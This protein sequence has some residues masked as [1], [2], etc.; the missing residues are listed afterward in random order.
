MTTKS[1]L[2]DECESVERTL[3]FTALTE[4]QQA[5]VLALSSEDEKR[6]LVAQYLAV[7]AEGDEESA[8]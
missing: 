4:A 6:A 7:V 5:D 1:I 2:I 3:Y 8:R